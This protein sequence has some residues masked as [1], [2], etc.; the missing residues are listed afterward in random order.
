MKQI[1]TVLA[2]LISGIASA[3]STWNVSVCEGEL[4]YNGHN[5]EVLGDLLTHNHMG[6]LPGGGDRNPGGWFCLETDDFTVA[7]NNFNRYFRW[8]R[9][10]TEDRKVGN[11]YTD[12]IDAI[13]RYN[14]PNGVSI[15]VYPTNYADGHDGRLGHIPTAT[16]RAGK[17]EVQRPVSRTSRFL[18]NSASFHT[19]TLEAWTWA[20]TH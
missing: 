13:R 4:V 11:E 8:Y 5:Y 9:G 3:Q 20:I 14:F 17:F 19:T 12:N 10:A 7:G 16:L 6:N 2:I 18:G 1:I 15:W